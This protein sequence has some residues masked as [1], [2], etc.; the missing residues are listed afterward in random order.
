MVRGLTVVFL[1]LAAG[2]WADQP[3]RK[4]DKKSSQVAVP[5]P[6]YDRLHPEAK[7]YVELMRE[8][9]RNSRG[10]AAA[11]D[12]FGVTCHAYQLYDCAETSYR[13]AH[14]LS[15]KRF[16]YAYHLVLV[17]DRKKTTPE[18]LK[19]LELVIQM[20]PSY[21]PSHWRLGKALEDLG[22]Q[23]DALVVFDRLTQI[24]PQS[25]LGHKGAGEILL[26]RGKMKKA[27]EHLE[28]AMASLPKD[29][30]TYAS[31]A[32]SYQ[33]LGDQDRASE[34]KL[35]SESLNTT[36]ALED[37]I[38]EGVRQR[39][40]AGTGVLAKAKLD[41]SMGRYKESIPGLLMVLEESPDDLMVHLLLATCFR[42]TD[43]LQKGQKHAEKALHLD[44]SSM[45][46]QLELAA[47]YIKMGE[48]DLGLDGYAR[49]QGLDPQ[50]GKIDTWIGDF[51]LQQGY[52]GH[53]IA[54]Y[55]RAALYD[56]LDA[57]AH[58]KWGLALGERGDMSGAINHFAAAIQMDANFANAHYSLGM[59]Y[60]KLNKPR[61]A[62]EQYRMAIGI[63]P[64]HPASQPLQRLEQQSP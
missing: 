50:N 62:I 48:L 16:F 26:A 15:P 64:K 49:A 1:L 36:F 44:G 45:S 35:K 4:A 19:L 56:A 63:N 29:G 42:A 28:Q 23:D 59:A 58:W 55:E 21:L 33:R 3:E 60:E 18:F 34:M 20:R 37:P 51:L 5:R 40:R 47:I 52:A 32:I 6:S 22:R 8:T 14:R 38:L 61:K 31:L 54:A 11:W 53:A 13:E 41:V 39:Q 17:L 10:S 43:Q 9:V 7:A 25:A 46:A 12:E 57:N 24:A 2:S 27:I 30:S